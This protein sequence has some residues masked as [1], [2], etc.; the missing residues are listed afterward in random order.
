VSKA[1]LGSKDSQGF[2]V[3]QD[4][5]GRLVFKVF[6]EIREFRVRLVFRVRLEYREHRA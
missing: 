6:K 4:F 3:R 2:R 5:R 1:R